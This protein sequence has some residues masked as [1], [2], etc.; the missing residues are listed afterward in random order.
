[1]DALFTTSKPRKAGGQKCLT[2]S[3]TRLGD[4]WK[5]FAT[6]VILKL[7]QISVQLFGG[8]WITSLLFWF[9]L[10]IYWKIWVTFYSTIWS[11]CFCLQ[12]TQDKFENYFESLFRLKDSVNYVKPLGSS[13]IDSLSLR[14][15]PLLA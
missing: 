6:N 14:R 2:T 12:R 11:H 8:F 4:F 9:H 10:D 15:F 5:F 1:M 7:A 13:P 3:V